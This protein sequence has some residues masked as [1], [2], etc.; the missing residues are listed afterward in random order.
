[1][2]IEPNL[3]QAYLDNSNQAY[4]DW[5]AGIIGEQTGQ[6][7]PY[8]VQPSLDTLKK[9]FRTWYENHREWLYQLICVQ[10]EYMRKRQEY[11]NQ[12]DLIFAILGDIASLADLIPL[13]NVPVTVILLVSEG[14]L[15]QLCI[16]GCGPQN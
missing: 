9:R 12:S 10:W 3:I 14:L 16:S 13:L 7:V 2:T 15:D 8:A 1:M 5:Y 11:S 4:Q 6:T